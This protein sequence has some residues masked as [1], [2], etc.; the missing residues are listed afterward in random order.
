MDE[1]TTEPTMEITYHY[2]EG[3]SDSLSC[4]LLDNNRRVQILVNDTPLYEGRAG[5]VEKVRT[6]LQHLINGETVDTD[7]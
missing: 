3:G 7:W 1:K 5:F 4:Y 6:E 2:T